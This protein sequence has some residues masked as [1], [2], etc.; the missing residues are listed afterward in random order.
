MKSARNSAP[1]PDGIP[2]AMYKIAPSEVINAFYAAYLDWM[3]GGPLPPGF[4]LSY[5]WLIPKGT[6]ADDSDSHT[7]RAPHTRARCQERTL[8]RNS[9]PRASALCWILQR[10]RGRAALNVDS[11]TIATLRTTF[12]T[13]STQHSKMPL[14]LP[15]QM[16][17]FYWI[18]KPRFRAFRSNSLS[19]HAEKLVCTTT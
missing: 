12:L 7:R 4:N 3:H 15:L 9:S 13:L 1:G 18:S 17:R 11:S 8:T 2:Y 19:K 10:A 6:G 14:T 16:Q 5:L